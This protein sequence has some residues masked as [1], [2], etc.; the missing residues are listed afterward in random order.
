MFE[1]IK[2]L[3]INY[4]NAYDFSYMYSFSKVFPY[5]NEPVESQF[6]LDAVVP[7]LAALCNFPRHLS[8]HMETDSYA[9]DMRLEARFFPEP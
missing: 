7:S 5:W 3:I 9:L 6:D 2:V 1:L 8:S 4:T